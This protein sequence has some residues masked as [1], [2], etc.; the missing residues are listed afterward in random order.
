MKDQVK[1][2]IKSEGIIPIGAV[3]TGKAKIPPPIDV[4]LINKMAPKALEYI[5]NFLDSVEEFI[6]TI[7][8]L[9]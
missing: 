4:P 8:K 6:L 2:K 9:R 3:I 7:K 1:R 5:S